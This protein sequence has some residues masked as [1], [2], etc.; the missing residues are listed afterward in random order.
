MVQ[1]VHVQSS[2]LESVGYDA[3][4]GTLEVGFLDGSVY[5][6]FNVPSSIYEGL[7]S[8]ASHGHFLDVHVKKA[9]YRYLK[10]R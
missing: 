6:Y 4:T 7:M 10:V 3:Q 5:Q 1:R 2:N 9:G 8:A